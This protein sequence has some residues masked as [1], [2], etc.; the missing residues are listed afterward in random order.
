MADAAHLRA[1]SGALH[2]QQF[3]LRGTEMALGRD[4]RECHIVFPADTTAVSRLHASI[5]WDS[6]AGVAIVRDEGSKNGTFVR[7][8]GQLVAGVEYRLRTGTQFW[9]GHPEQMFV[10]TTD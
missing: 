3:G 6:D 5:W 4:R 8:V 2:G 1:L 10:I 7:G 9:L